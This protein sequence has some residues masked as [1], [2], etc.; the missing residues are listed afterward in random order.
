MRELFEMT[1]HDLDESIDPTEFRQI[2]RSKSVR[3]WLAA[4]DLNVDDVDKL[5][6][7]LSQDSNGI[8]LEDL[9]KGVAHLRGTAKSID[10]MEMMR[11]YERLHEQLCDL[12]ALFRGQSKLPAFQAEEKVHM[13]L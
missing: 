2:M 13:R 3:T 5:Y 1:D 6:H 8:S 4:M 11:Q 12:Q 10:I 7:L 9:T